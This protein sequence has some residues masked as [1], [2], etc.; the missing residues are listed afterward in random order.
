MMLNILAIKKLRNLNLMR[1]D[2]MLIINNNWYIIIKLCRSDQFTSPFNCRGY[3]HYLNALECIRLIYLTYTIIN[4]SWFL[5]YPA[6]FC[7]ARMHRACRRQQPVGPL[8]PYDQR[9]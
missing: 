3:L 6:V 5:A 8:E 2:N 1:F 7:S 9:T 4:M